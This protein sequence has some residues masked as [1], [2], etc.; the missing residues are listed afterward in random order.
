MP[1][2]PW[3]V[4]KSFHAEKKG[5]R[6]SSDLVSIVVGSLEVSVTSAMVP[7]ASRRKS[8]TKIKVHHFVATA[9]TNV[10]AVISVKASRGAGRL[11]GP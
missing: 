10:D 9:M 4:C 5:A 8:G 1:V 7:S 3:P 2:A 11:V 6:V